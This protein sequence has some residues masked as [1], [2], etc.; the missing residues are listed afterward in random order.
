[1]VDNGGNSSIRLTPDTH[2]IACEID[3]PQTATA[4]ELEELIET[5]TFAGGGMSFL[6]LMGDGNFK[7]KVKTE[8]GQQ[9]MEVSQFTCPEVSVTI[10]PSFSGTSIGITED[11]ACECDCPECKSGDCDNCSCV[12]CQCDNCSCGS[13][14][15]AAKPLTAHDR[16]AQSLKL[17]K[18]RLDNLEI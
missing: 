6:M 14:M 4:K 18:I 12:N 9:V 5:G 7:G 11:D 17:Q 13:T 16:T 10:I 8:N 3:L 1:M 2:G 15:E